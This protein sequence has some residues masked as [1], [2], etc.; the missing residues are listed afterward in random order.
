MVRLRASQRG[1]E[2]FTAKII[3][4]FYLADNKTDRVASGGYFG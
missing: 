1:F 2:A 4:A 3:R